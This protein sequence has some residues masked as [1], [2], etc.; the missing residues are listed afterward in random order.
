MAAGG[1]KNADAA[2]L[3]HLAGGATVRTAA[4]K[5]G[6]SE[7]TAFR[8]LADE[9]FRRRV[10]EARGAMLG[11][12]VGRLSATATAAAAELRKLL[13]AADAKVRL[14]AAVAVLT[15]GPRLRESE[16]LEE[17]IRILEELVEN[18]K[19]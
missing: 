15:L 18:Q 7:R 3:A 14:R 16:E 10:A 5:A 8:R 17:R 19:P 13:K 2:L 11:R 1:R 12:A 6:V 4:A 9:A